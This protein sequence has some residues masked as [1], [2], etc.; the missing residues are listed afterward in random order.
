M[1]RLLETLLYITGYSTINVATVWCKIKNNMIS[2][3]ILMIDLNFK[4]AVLNNIVEMWLIRFFACSLQVC[5]SL[6]CILRIWI[7]KCLCK[8]QIFIDGIV[9]LFSRKLDLYDWAPFTTFRFNCLQGSVRE[10]YEKRVRKI[11]CTYWLGTLKYYQRLLDR[12]NWQGLVLLTLADERIGARGL[13]DVETLPKKVVGPKAIMCSTLILYFGW[14][15]HI[16]KN[17]VLPMEWPTKRI[18]W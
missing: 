2:I 18:C 8:T 9:F 14:L 1:I 16:T 5:K 6:I 7:S 15:A 4:T 12:Y 3:F 10:F 17:A 13:R 11:D